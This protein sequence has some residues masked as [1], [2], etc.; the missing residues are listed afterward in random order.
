[1]NCLLISLTKPHCTLGSLYMVH[2]VSKKMFKINILY[3]LLFINIFS[4]VYL[5]H[6]WFCIH[7]CSR[8]HIL[9][10]VK[11]MRTNSI[12]A[13]RIAFSI[14]LLKLYAMSYVIYVIFMLCPIYMCYINKDIDGNEVNIYTFFEF[15]ICLLFKWQWYKSHWMFL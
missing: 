15:P 2:G 1:M 4:I 13:K 10:G 9:F 3:C 8:L 12:Y 14:L 6:S 7:L 5:Q 11:K